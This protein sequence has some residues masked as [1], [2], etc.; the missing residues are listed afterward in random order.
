VFLDIYVYFLLQLTYTNVLSP[1]CKLDTSL[2]GIINPN[3]VDK[4]SGDVLE[5][6]GD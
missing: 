1:F 3:E 2:K 5:C 6:L 4:A